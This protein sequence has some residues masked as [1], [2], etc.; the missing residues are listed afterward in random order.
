MR[1]HNIGGE[2]MEE[3]EKVDIGKTRK[4]LDEYREC[5]AGDSFSEFIG[6]GT[7]ED[8]CNELE[9]ARATI[10]ELDSELN[11]A[12]EELAKNDLQ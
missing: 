6:E 4:L 1:T 12:Y 8:F 5:R 7:V 2:I 3:D 10:E 11:S 9:A